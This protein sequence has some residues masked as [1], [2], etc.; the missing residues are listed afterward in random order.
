MKKLFIILLV[1]SLWSCQS[2]LDR[3]YIPGRYEVD[4][5]NLVGAE[6]VTD[7]EMF[8]I[9]YAIL[10]ATPYN[11][12]SVEG[13]TFAEILQ[14]G[15]DKEANGLNINYEF[16]ADGK[17]EPFD[18]TL[19]NDGLGQVRIGE[20]SRL[21]KALNFNCVFENKSNK[22][23]FLEN[24]T[25]QFYGPF[26]DHLSSA[27]YKIDVLFKPGEKKSIN[28][29]ADAKN[30]SNNIKHL[31]DERMTITRIDDIL[32][33]SEIKFTGSTFASKTPSLVAVRDF[34]KGRFPPTKSYS[35]Y[36]ELKDNTWIKRDS[37]GKVT[38]LS[39]GSAKLK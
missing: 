16:Q 19:R 15:K 12:Y 3:N 11:D 14:I 38:K 17:E 23:I 32:L 29:Y 5:K 33:L 26:K 10:R 21:K 24:S 22:E 7:H 39:L 20:S 37:K 27:M 6:V 36:K 4:Y 18:C 35:Y 30:I 13:K 25:F 2:P 28:F 1:A 31:A 34:D 9:N 8:L